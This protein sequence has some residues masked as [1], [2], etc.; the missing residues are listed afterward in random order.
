MSSASGPRPA[1]RRSAGFTLLE[2]LAA[3]LILSVSL[4]AIFGVFAAAAGI[5]ERVRTERSAAAVA[6]SQLA[7]VGRE[8]PLNLGTLEGVTADGF[9]WIVEIEPFRDAAINPLAVLRPF[10]VAV[11]VARGRHQ[12]SLTTLR[13]AAPT[14]VS[15]IEP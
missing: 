3:L 2:V 4:S 8:I 5:T 6:Q 14:D 12:L 10:R 9:S 13:L 1:A 15:G 7:R 11:S